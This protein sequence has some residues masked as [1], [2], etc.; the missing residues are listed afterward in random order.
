M[1]TD[2]YEKVIEFDGRQMLEAWLEA[3][4]YGW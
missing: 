4:V 1:T 3:K 2:R